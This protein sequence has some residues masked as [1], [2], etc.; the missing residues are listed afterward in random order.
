MARAT[1]TMTAAELSGIASATALLADTGLTYAAG[2]STSVSAGDV[3]RA[4]TNDH[5]WRVA[6]SDAEDHHVTTAGGIKLYVL[7]DASG[8]YPVG[9]FGA[10]G[11]GVTDDTDSVQSAIDI[12]TAAGVPLMVPGGPYLIS[13]ITTKCPIVGTVNNRFSSG[14]ATFISAVGAD[15]WAVIV[16]GVLG[17]LAMVTVRNTGAGNGIWVKKSS[18]RAAL[19][20]VSA[21]STY[22]LVTGSGS[23]GVK[24]GTDA[25]PGDQTITASIHDV[26]VRGYDICHHMAYYSNANTYQELCALNTDNDGP[27]SSHGFLIDSRGNQFT[28]LQCESNFEVSLE[29]TSISYSNTITQYWAEGAGSGDLAVIIGGTKNRLVNPIDPIGN[30]G[31]GIPTT[32]GATN[33]LVK[34]HIN[35]I[36]YEDFNRTSG[37][38]IRGAD[39]AGGLVS[40]YWSGSATPTL[41]GSSVFGFPTVVV[42]NPAGG[43]AYADYLASDLDLNTHTWLRGKA[44]TFACFGKGESGVSISLRA[45]IQNAAGSNTQYAQSLFFDADWDIYKCVTRIPE[46]EADARYLRFRVYATGAPDDGTGKAGEIACPTIILGE[47]LAHMAPRFVGD[48]ANTLYGTQTISGGGWDGA[49][50]MLGAHHLWVDAS[51]VLRIKS[52]APTSDTDGTVVGAQT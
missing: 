7:P 27:S 23:I 46:A 51:G 11:D 34:R 38:L 42:A 15:E 37:N 35:Q 10:V 31:G 14:S 13:T 28:G 39:M 50:L 32:I 33:E 5:A 47:D 41:S 29:T 21:V 3:I 26:T 40:P 9:A 17:T 24:Y 4:K 44:V 8:R 49:H 16:D 52:G 6:A 20:D 1:L 30:V 18:T 45:M 43:T 36:T 19:H 12:C 2:T 22:T 25:D 48:G